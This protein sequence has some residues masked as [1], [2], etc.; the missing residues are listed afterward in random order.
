MGLRK[1]IPF[2]NFLTGR[3]K[4]YWKFRSIDWEVDYFTPHHF[5]RDLVVSI[6]KDLNIKSVFEVG[7]AS[8]A[9]LARIKEE[10]PMVEIGGCDIAPKAI[11]AAKRLLGDNAEVL[12]V[13]SAD[14]IFL[15]DK[16][17]DVVL[18][19]M[20]L[21]YIDP[22]HINKAI[23]EFNRISRNYVMFVE[24]HDLKWWKRIPCALFNGYNLYNYEKLLKRH[25]FYDIKTWEV[26]NLEI[27]HTGKTVTHQSDIY[28]FKRKIP[29]S[30]HV[31]LARV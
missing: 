27:G 15:S 9:N 2:K 22:F 25:G 4:H 11:E 29:I 23:K 10:L 12:E 6:I 28:L 18:T 16:S 19:D 8:G 21:I 13:C 5:K 17:V 3:H 24:F 30:A 14:E 26:R 1:Y 31:V 7:C 20:C